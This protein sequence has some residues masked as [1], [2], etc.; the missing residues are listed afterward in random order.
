MS[1]EKVQLTEKARVT[2]EKVLNDSRDEMAGR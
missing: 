2:M 1:L